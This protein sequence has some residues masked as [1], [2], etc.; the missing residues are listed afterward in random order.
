MTFSLLVEGIRIVVRICFGFKPNAMVTV[1]SLCEGMFVVK[2][3]RT[4]RGNLLVKARTRLTS[5][6]ADQLRRALAH[7]CVVEVASATTW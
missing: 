4:A 1:G 7:D 3:V 2:D 6:L 5:T